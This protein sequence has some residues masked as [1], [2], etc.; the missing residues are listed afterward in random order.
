MTGWT[1]AEAR[2]ASGV[3]HSQ[4]NYWSATRFIRPSIHVARGSGDRRAYDLG[5]VLELTTARALIDAGVRLERLREVWPD[6]RPTVRRGGA[7]VV[8]G[9][10]VRP[11]ET[12]AELVASI[13]R[14]PAGVRTVV[15]VERLAAELLEAA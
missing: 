14:G 11:A 9:A 6:V 3:T 4:I 12:D 15:I 13:E 1:T 5:D 10:D 8:L 7:L 2:A